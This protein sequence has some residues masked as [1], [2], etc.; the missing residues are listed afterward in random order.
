M[1]IINQLCRQKTGIDIPDDIEKCLIDY[2]KT[3]NGNG[4]VFKLLNIIDCK[5][6]NQFCE[7]LNGM[8]VKELNG[9]RKQNDIRPCELVGTGKN[10]NVGREDLIRG[11]TGR[12]LDQKYT[13]NF[14][15]FVKDSLYCGE[16]YRYGKT[17]KYYTSTQMSKRMTDFK[18]AFITQE[19]RDNIKTIRMIQEKTG[20]HSN[21]A[22]LYINEL[23]SNDYNKHYTE[24]LEEKR[25]YKYINYRGHDRVKINLPE[26]YETR[27]KSGY[28]TT[29]YKLN[30]YR[31]KKKHQFY[32]YTDKYYCF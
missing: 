30:E 17:E 31:V 27:P 29:S 22:E 15:E 4:K 1:S 23:L 13:T 8:T 7:S 10:C 20:V 25:K 32:S 26:L 16:R 11:I 14:R 18:S 3:F 24:C 21:N 5:F 28:M 6:K 19:T 12:Y 2:I 9:V